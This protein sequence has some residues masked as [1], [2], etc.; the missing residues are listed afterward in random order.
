MSTLPTKIEFPSVK[1]SSLSNMLKQ[2][3]GLISTHLLKMSH[4]GADP[5]FFNRGGAK[6]YEAAAH[7]KST[8]CKIP[9]TPRVQGKHNAIWALF[10][11]ILIQNKLT[12]HCQSKLLRRG[13]VPFA[14]L[15]GLATVNESLW[16]Y[17]IASWEHIGYSSLFWR[18]AKNIQ[19]L[20]WDLLFWR[21][22]IYSEGLLILKIK[23]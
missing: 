6:N 9:Y 15:P 12:K 2:F 18:F 13:H 3:E 1:Q 8:K 19:K 11:N 21:S 16:N 22:I 23:K 14:P 4:S 10:W 5:G 17:M 7:I 20:K